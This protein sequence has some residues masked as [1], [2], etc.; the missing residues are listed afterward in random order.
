L[1]E[2]HPNDDEDEVGKGGKIDGDAPFS[3]AK[4]SEG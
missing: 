2:G 4:G 3:E 1:R